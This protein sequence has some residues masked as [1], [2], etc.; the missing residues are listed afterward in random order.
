MSQLEIPAHT[1]LTVQEIFRIE[2]PNTMHGMWYRLSG[3]YDPF[4]KTLTDGISAD[5]PMDP[6]E[7]YGQLNQ[8]WFSGCKDFEQLKLWFSHQDIIELNNAGYK[9][10]KFEST[11]YQNEDVQTIFTRRGIISQTE[12]SIQ[13]LLA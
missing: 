13:D 9:L 1:P 4:I 10:F 7:R 8:R 2:N 11:E 5:L 3:E 6:H 12:I